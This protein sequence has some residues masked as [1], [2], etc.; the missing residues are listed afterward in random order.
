MQDVA[1]VSLI[2]DELRLGSPSAN[3]YEIAEWNLILASGLPG[4]EH[5]KIAPLLDKLDRWT[6]QVQR[7]TERHYY[8]FLRDPGEYNYSQGYFCVLVLVTVLE[9]DL[10]VRYNPE[11]VR[12]ATF[13]DPYCVDPD[14]RD[15]RDLFIHG[16]LDGPGGTCSSMPAIY[17]A[18]G[19]RL[20]YPI[21]LVE[22]PGHLFSRW[23]DPLG[24]SNGIP[25][26]FNIDASGHGFA[27]QPDRTLQV[28]ASSLDTGR[29]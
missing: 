14:F 25:D 8:R 21:S 20:G 26:V 11:R 5:L 3:E 18:V 4:A 22:A 24:T 27:C 23:D 17:T 9:R 7:E 29:D 19:R 12:D 10:G 16:I 15:S 1:L 28:M 13:Q 6:D 2:R